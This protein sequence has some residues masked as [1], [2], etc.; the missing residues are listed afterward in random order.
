[1]ARMMRLFI[2]MAVLTAGLAVTPALARRSISGTIGLAVYRIDLPDHFNDWNGD[3]IVFAHGYVNPDRPLEIPEDQL[4][5]AGQYVPDVV[6]GMG[7]AFAVTSYSKNGLAVVQGMQDV[8]NL[9]E[10]FKNVVQKPRHVFLA[11]V[12]EGALITTLAVEQHPEIFSGGLAL[13]G[14]IGDFSRQINYMGDFRIVF[15]YFFPNLL[16]PTPINIPPELM[17]NWYSVYV[18]EITQAINSNTDATNQLLNVT[19]APIDPDNWTTR[20]QTALAILWYNVFGTNVG[21]TLG[22]QP[23]DNRHRLYVGSNNDLLLNFGVARFQADSAALNEIQAHYQ[24]SGKLRR[25]LVTMH[26]SRDPVVPFWHE[27]LYLA[28]VIAKGSLLNF[29]TFPV[30]RYGHSNFTVNELQEGFA[31]LVKMVGEQDWRRKARNA[32]AINLLLLDGLQ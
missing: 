9:V 1:M 14:P 31:I 2:F 27:E 17:K 11:G 23:F 19:R 8:L 15:D 6:T 3:L 16:P 28:K 26:T 12:S 30:F 22:G 32:A 5:V 29:F 4:S 13:C 18:P 20:E 21:T 7:Y 10:V 24:T 25:P